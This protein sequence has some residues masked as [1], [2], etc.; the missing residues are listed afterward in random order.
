MGKFKVVIPLFLALIIAGGSSLFLFNWI[1]SIRPQ[2]VIEKT[3]DTDTTSIIVAA[4]YIPFG[5]KISKEMLKTVQYPA[6][7]LPQGSFAESDQIIDRILVS[8]LIENEPVLQGKLAPEDVKLGGVAAVLKP[9]KRAMAVKGDKIIGISGFIR[10]GNLVDVFVTVQN[11][12][13]KK[14]TTKLVLDKILVLATGEEIQA[15]GKK[16]ASPVDV[17]TLE[18]TPDQGEKLALASTQGKLQFA[19]RNITD[20]ETVLTRGATIAETLRS[21]SA[22]KRSPRAK[23]KTKRIYPRLHTME[24]IIGD[25]IIKRKMKL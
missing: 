22:N 25:K 7:T 2:T 23:S 10:P 1:R 19:L 18:V 17:Y 15:D 14:D 16:N 20:S 4:H 11:P 5:T 21:L 6:T 24:I 8:P 13:T 9:G 12:E 3:G